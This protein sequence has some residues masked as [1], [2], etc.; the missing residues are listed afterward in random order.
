MVW[1]IIRWLTRIPMIKRVLERW[2][3]R[4]SFH[5]AGQVLAK[6]PVPAALL[7]AAV[8]IGAVRYQLAQPKLTP[9]TVAWY[10]D[11]EELINLDGVVVDPPDERDTYTNLRVAVDGLRLAD[12]GAYLPVKGTVL[13]RVPPGGEWRY[14]DRIS[15]AGRLETPQS[16]EGFSYR[17]YLMRQGIYT[18]IQPVQVSLLLQNQGNPFKAVVY[19]LKERLLNTVYRIFPD[20]EASL[21]AGI[22]LGVEAGIPQD[23]QDAFQATGTSHV[24]AISGFNIAVLA[25]L[26]TLLFSRVAGRW[27]GALLAAVGIAF[28]TLLVGA[29]ASVVRAA[30]MGWVGLLGVQIG[31]RQDGL[32]SLGIVAGIMAA[33]NPTI[34]WDVGFQLSFMATLGLVLYADP[35]QTA[36]ERLAARW[37][38]APLVERAGKLVGETFLLTLAAQALVLPVT[39]YHFQRLSLTMLV[40][41]PLI[42]PVQPAVMVLGGLAVLAGAISQPLGQVLGYL[43]WPFLA[44]TIRAVEGLAALP[45]GEVSLGN[46][47]LGAVLAFYSLVFLLTFARTQPENKLSVWLRSLNPSVP[48]VGL[49]LLTVLVWR[50]A[51]AAPDSLLHLTVLDVSQGGLSGEALLIETPDGQDLLINGG[52]STSRLSEALGRRLP[53]WGDKLDVLVVAG[54][55]NGQLQALPAVVERYPPGQV[56]WAGLTQAT[57]AS[58]DLNEKLVEM[59]VPWMSAEAGQALDLGAGASLRVLAAGERGA[60]LLLDWQNFRALLPLGMSFEEMDALENGRRIGRVSALLL[61]DS[62]YAPLNPPE[63]VANLQPQVVLLS[64]S[65][66]DVTGLPNSEALQAVEGYTVLRTDRNGWIKL[67]TDGEQM[68]VEAER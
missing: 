44:Y 53:L 38:P 1:A 37:L 33:F 30:L 46:V 25:G 31:R 34:L 60:V 18:I 32:N 8:F 63:W 15:L 36:F 68:W 2:K 50:Q 55:Q 23:V 41:N 22:L 14:G 12:E 47:S 54:V 28:Y 35:I 49:G 7:L 42:L 4:R 27:W 26:F 58:R 11:G 21:L 20:P 48:L 5:L 6:L 24:I 66:K 57:R 17:D 65:L 10:N 45:G 64:V 29:G 40:A 3:Q 62:G 67:S 52:P 61:A 9:E 43:A 51:F 56:L 16:E 19:C 39:V 59:K 13:A